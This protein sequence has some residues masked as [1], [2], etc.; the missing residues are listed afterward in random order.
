[1]EALRQT[2]LPQHP[3]LQA[4]ISPGPPSDN[5][6]FDVSASRSHELRRL[7]K[8]EQ[9]LAVLQ[10]TNEADLQRRRSQRRQLAKNSRIRLRGA[11]GSERVVNDINLGLGWQRRSHVIVDG[12][13]GVGILHQACI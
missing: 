7:E 5:N 3:S 12:H 8:I 11:L 4:T 9:A 13:H 10:I 2:Q 6:K 1:M